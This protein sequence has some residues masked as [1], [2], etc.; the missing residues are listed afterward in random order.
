MSK[1]ISDSQFAYIPHLGSGTVSALVT[2]EH[3][4][5][6]FLDSDSGAV[7]FLSTDFSK[8]FDK[9]PHHVIVSSC[10][11]FNLPDAVIGFVSSFLTH[12]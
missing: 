7:R 11:S 4:I 10:Q 12:R 8:A 3:K 2:V 5:L 9:I 1:Q 6:Q